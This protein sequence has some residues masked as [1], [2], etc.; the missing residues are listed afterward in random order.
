[1]Q[2]GCTGSKRHCLFEVEQTCPWIKSVRHPIKQRLISNRNRTGA[3]V[4]RMGRSHD[5]HP[6]PGNHHPLP[7]F[8]LFVCYFYFCIEPGDLVL[9]TLDCLVNET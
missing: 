4:P 8:F 7:A 9:M 3:K 5:H 2:L 6:T 1:M